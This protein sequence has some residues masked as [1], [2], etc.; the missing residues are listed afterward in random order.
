MSP[1]NEPV[2]RSVWKNQKPL[3]EL[4]GIT[5]FKFDA[6]VSPADRFLEEF[7]MIDLHHGSFSSGAHYTEL[8]VVGVPMTAQI[9]E[10]LSNA[11]FGRFDEKQAGFTAKRY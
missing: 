4:N 9:L 1:I 8:E 2:I 11:G 5:S 7:D 6:D 10:V 3:N